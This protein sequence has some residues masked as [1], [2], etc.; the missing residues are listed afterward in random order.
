MFVIPFSTV[1]VRS[2]ERRGGGGEIEKIIQ[3]VVDTEGIPGS[4][5]LLSHNYIF[6]MRINRTVNR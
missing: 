1:D 3:Q 4:K 2:G 6:E 5:Y